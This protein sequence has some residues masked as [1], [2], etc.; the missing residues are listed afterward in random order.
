MFREQ[1]PELLI[2]LPQQQQQQSAV[3][4]AGDAAAGAAP[5]GADSSK[6][7][8]SGAAVSGGAAAP[9]ASAGAPSPAAPAAG[10]AAGAAAGN[11]PPALLQLRICITFSK[12]ASS[13]SSLD[14]CLLVRQQCLVANA[15]LRRSRGWF[16]CVDSPLHLYSLGAPHYI[17][18]TFDLAL[19][20]PPS[21]MAVCSGVL[22]QQTAS[23]APRP[24]ATAGTGAAAAD[25]IVART[26]EYR[27]EVP[28]APSQ[29]SIAV[30]PFAA[31]PYADLL[32]AAGTPGIT[33]PDGSPAVTVFVLR[34]SSSSSSS[35]SAQQQQQQQQQQQRG[36]GDTSNSSIEAAAAAAAAA[37]S[38]LR[39]WRL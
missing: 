29:L 12:P 24:A 32:A 35:P 3:A 1:E 26:F 23:L 25:V 20:V 8:G 14:S 28:V 6:A 19:T 16:P 5:G 36:T 9:A 30:G 21:C 38:V 7:G 4:A 31:V 34:S 27:M 18:Y 2:T 13:S 10:A 37:G 11:E 33:L 39:A 15:L 17:P 22:A